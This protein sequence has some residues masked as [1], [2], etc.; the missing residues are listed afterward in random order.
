MVKTE[1]THAQVS[2]ERHLKNPILNDLVSRGNILRQK[3]VILRK[4][5][6]DASSKWMAPLNKAI[7][8][9][10]RLQDFHIKDAYTVDFSLRQ[11]AVKGV[12]QRIKVQ[13]SCTE[14]QLS[15]IDFKIDSK[16]L[17]EIWA[18]NN[19]RKNYVGDKTNLPVWLSW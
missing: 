9:M 13:S 7:V 18:L 2:E 8:K 19:E 6:K 4:I 11:I 1:K 15:V 16:W 10:F 12:E 5:G 14:P 17:S 3:A